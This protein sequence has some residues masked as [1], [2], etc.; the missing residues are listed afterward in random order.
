MAREKVQLLSSKKTG[1]DQVKVDKL[2]AEL[3]AAPEYLDYV[4]RSRG[5]Q[6]Y[7]R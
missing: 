7:S 6:D 3:D 2:E 5:L 1:Y 4:K